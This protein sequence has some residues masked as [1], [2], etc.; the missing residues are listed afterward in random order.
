MTMNMERGLVLHA[1][2]ASS[3]KDVAH[4][5]DLACCQ[6][7]MQLGHESWTFKCC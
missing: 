1:L 3:L 5:T 2:L 4:G 7:L 6:A